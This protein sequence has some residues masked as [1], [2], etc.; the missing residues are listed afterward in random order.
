MTEYLLPLLGG[1]LIGL[2]SLL[3]MAGSGKVPGISGVTAKI[4]RPSPGD[5]AWRVIFL[6]GLV[7]GAGL[8]FALGVGHTG[9]TLPACRNLIVV[10]I[11]GLLVG[12]GAR[13]G[14]GCTS[15]HGVCGMGSAAR[16]GIVYTIVFMVA[17]AVIVFLWRLLVEGRLS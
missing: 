3:A 10:G 16:D 2:G 4:L 1:I 8:M 7:S 6:I 5:A 17:A 9:F 15:G 13:V 11:A 14:G 12:F